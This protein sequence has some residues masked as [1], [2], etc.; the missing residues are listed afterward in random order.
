M[1]IRVVLADDH[2]TVRSGLKALLER[3]E[4]IEVVGEASDG[5]AAV[6][7][8]RALRPDV[9][10][11]DVRMPVVD[12]V[13]ATR[14]IVSEGTAAVLVLTTFD[15]DEVVLSAIRAGAAGFLLKTAEAGELVSAVRRV[16]AGDGVVAPEVTRRVFREL[17]TASARNSPTGDGQ[18]TAL[19]ESLT[20]RERDVLAQLGAGASNSQL[21][22]ELGISEATAKTHVSRVL[23]KLGVQSRT[24]A[25]LVARDAGLMDST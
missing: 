11:M 5:A 21:A 25:A 14:E 20:V 22:R 6:V 2:G 18:A 12:G 17:S 24:Q 8:A 19:L 9:V 4:G 23:A 1:S 3:A 10:L 16:A 13:A 15:E 7:N